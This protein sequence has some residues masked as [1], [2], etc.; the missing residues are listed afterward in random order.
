MCGI[1]RRVVAG[2]IAVLRMR[3]RIAKLR[4]FDLKR[5]AM[6]R[7]WHLSELQTVLCL[8]VPA[9]HGARRCSMCAANVC[10]PYLGCHKA[11]RWQRA[12]RRLNKQ[13]APV[14]RRW[15]QR[16]KAP[17]RGLFVDQLKLHYS[18]SFFSMRSARGCSPSCQSHISRVGNVSNVCSGGGL[19]N[20]HSSVS[21]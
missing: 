13:G 6:F 15:L 16:K 20:V 14:L 8:C 12:L 19:G 4:I 21:A 9:W 1:K 11:L 3:M 18:V 5:R 17:R 2:A 7:A 10:D